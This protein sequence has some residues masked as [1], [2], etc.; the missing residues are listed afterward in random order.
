MAQPIETARE[1]SRAQFSSVR[2]ALERHAGASTL[3]ADGITGAASAAAK[4]A[5]NAI[6]EGKYEQQ[7]VDADGN[8][9]TRTVEINNH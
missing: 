4:A 9:K 8:Q 6:I 1:Y 7:Y 2:D 5:G 3:G